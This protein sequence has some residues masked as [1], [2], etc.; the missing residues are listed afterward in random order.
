M[1]LGELLGKEIIVK[2]DSRKLSRQELD[3]LDIPTLRENCDVFV[4]GSSC[5]FDG[6]DNQLYGTWGGMMFVIGELDKLT[7][8]AV[9]ETCYKGVKRDLP[10]RDYI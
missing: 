4:R 8:A 7:V 10:T 2:K 9:L 6:R 3:S 5:G 1:D